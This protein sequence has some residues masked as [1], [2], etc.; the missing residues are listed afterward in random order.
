MKKIFFLYVELFAHRILLRFYL[1]KN[2]CTRYDKKIK[3]IVKM[4]SN[5]R[6]KIANLLFLSFKNPLTFKEERK[7]T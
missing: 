4:Q 6:Y 5:S 3:I 2:C 1:V 7:V